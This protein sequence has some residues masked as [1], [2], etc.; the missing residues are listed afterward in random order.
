VSGGVGGVTRGATEVAAQRRNPRGTAGAGREAIGGSK[1]GG[2]FDASRAG[3]GW[4]PGRGNAASLRRRQRRRG[5]DHEH[6]CCDLEG[7]QQ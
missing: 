1:P 3:V 7:A 5:I 6:R 2:I 4:R